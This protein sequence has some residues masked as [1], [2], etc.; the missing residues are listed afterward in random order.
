MNINANVNRTAVRP[1]EETVREGK[2]IKDAL[3]WLFKEI[4]PAAF[5]SVIE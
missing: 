2:R 3:M 1:C 4:K 5:C